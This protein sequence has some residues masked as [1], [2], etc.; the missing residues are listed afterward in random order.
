[1]WLQV[2]VAHVDSNGTISDG[3]TLL[4]H[5]TRTGNAGADGAGSGDVVGPS[6]ATDLAV[7]R[8]DSTT[9]KLVQNSVVFIDDSDLM[10]GM[11]AK[12]NA[13]TGTTYTLALADMGK[14]V[15]LDSE[16]TTAPN[17]ASLYEVVA[18]DV[19]VSVSDTDLA[20][21]FVNTY[22]NTTTIT[23]DGAAVA[24]TDYYNGMIIVF[25]H[26]VGA[27]QSREITDYTS[28][29][30]V[31]M[32]PALITA[33]D[34]TTVWHIQATNAIPE[35]VDEVW[36]KSMTELAAVPGVTGTVLAALEWVFLMSRN[37]MTQTATTT[38]LRN[39]VDDGD[40]ATSTVSDDST[41]FTRGEYS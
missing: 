22:T 32:S 14:V 19:H 31:T 40:I 12:I 34:A 4:V 18:A 15:T 33:L 25:T 13:Q 39:D 27:G 24:T 20:G 8:F 2:P 6:S 7:C 11:G 16:F 38:T 35:I 23:L 41:T 28:G 36:A 37:K 5:W 10:Y 17:T 21:G 3:D 30:V 9:G 29:R 26:G 1:G